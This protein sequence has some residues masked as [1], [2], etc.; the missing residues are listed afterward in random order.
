MSMPAP[1]EKPMSAIRAEST[2]ETNGEPQ[3]RL[4]PAID[5][6]WTKWFNRLE[7]FTSQPNDWPPECG[8]FPSSSVIASVRAFLELLRPQGQQPSRL[9]AAVVGGIGLTF[10]CADRKVYVEFSNKGSVLAL[11][12]D[13]VTDPQVD[14]IPPDETGYSALIASIKTYLHE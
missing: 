3:A 13:G 1:R 12:S 5:P 6:Q 2:V 9:S 7:S 14:K 8:T 10:K 4:I 11:F